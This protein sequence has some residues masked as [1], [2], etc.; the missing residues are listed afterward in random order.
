[1]GDLEVAREV[2]A[3]L[4]DWQPKAGDNAIIE[5]AELAS[6][7]GRVGFLLLWTQRTRDQG[8]QRFGLLIALHEIVLGREVG[9]ADVERVFE[10][11]WLAVVEPHESAQPQARTMFAALP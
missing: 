6:I 5:S 3:R 9:T 10:D 11:L 7:E 4:R 1:M 2:V 8:A